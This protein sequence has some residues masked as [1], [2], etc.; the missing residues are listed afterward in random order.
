MD[1]YPM[2]APPEAMGNYPWHIDL[3]GQQNEVVGRIICRGITLRTIYGPL[4]EDGMQRPD[5]G[6]RRYRVDRKSR[7]FVMARG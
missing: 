1:P 7:E 3:Y 4:M 6:S 5:P 2:W